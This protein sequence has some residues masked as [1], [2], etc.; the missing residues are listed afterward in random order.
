MKFRDLIEDLALGYLA[1][2]GLV[3]G[4]E[5]NIAQLP[6]L[7][8]IINRS[9]EHFYSTLHL[10]DS[11]VLIR[12]NSGIS[13]Y[14]LN[15]DHT[16]SNHG[17]STLYDRE[18]YIMDSDNN[19]FVNTII[20]IH[21]VSTIEGKLLTIDD[22]NSSFGVLLPEYNCIHV[23]Y[24][25]GTNFLS[26]VYQDGHVRIP[27]Q[28]SPSSTFEVNIPI[29]LH[30][31][32]MNYIACLYL[33]SMGGANIQESNAYFATYRTQLELLQAQGIGVKSHTGL[34]I[35]PIIRGWI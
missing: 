8:Q 24:D 28:E 17:S 7:I 34:N 27:L 4:N 25:L 9:L 30:N 13:H 18:K 3:D 14:Y 33:Q 11:Q 1:G 16:I 10:K 12:L 5:I 23:P 29:P 21:T 20:Q 26:I 31:A 6:K 35:K 19:P 2:T 15:E 32:F 22:P